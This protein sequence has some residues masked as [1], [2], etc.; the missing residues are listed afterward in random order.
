MNILSKSPWEKNNTQWYLLYL[1]ECAVKIIFDT[2]IKISIKYKS[3]NNNNVNPW[4]ITVIYKSLCEVTTKIFVLTKAFQLDKHVALR[5]KKKICYLNFY[6]FKVKM[7]TSCDVLG[8]HVLKTPLGLDWD[9]DLIDDHIK[10]ALWVF[11]VF[12]VL[13]WLQRW[14]ISWEMTVNIIQW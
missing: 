1:N 2:Y 14:N 13:H 7:K 4:Q 6:S 5:D 12:S 10:Y 8:S 3:Y 11:F 9:V